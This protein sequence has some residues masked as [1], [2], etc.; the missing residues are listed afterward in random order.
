[1]KENC[2]DCKQLNEII[3]NM[4]NAIKKINLD[5]G[6]SGASELVE[7]LSPLGLID[8]FLYKILRIERYA[9]LFKKLEQN[10]KNFIPENTRILVCK[11]C[12][13]EFVTQKQ[14]KDIIYCYFSSCEAKYNIEKKIPIN[15]TQFI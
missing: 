3:I 10:K 15:N 8:E 9:S 4:V 14:F 13:R 2:E 7:I 1:M 5:G 11:Y 12:E 6:T